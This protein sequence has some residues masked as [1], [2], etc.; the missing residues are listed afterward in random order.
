ERERRGREE[1]DG[2]DESR[3]QR[4][5][6]MTRQERLER[7]GQEPHLDDQD[8]DD[9]PERAVDRGEAAPRR[10]ESTSREIPAA[11][12][13]SPRLS[14]RMRGSGRCGGPERTR[15]SFAEK[16]PSWHGHSMRSDSFE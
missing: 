12:S 14:M 7:G 1:E 5:L 8:E 4:G 11:I 16:K 10:H 15:P 2:G 3:R 6:T 13:W 9:Q